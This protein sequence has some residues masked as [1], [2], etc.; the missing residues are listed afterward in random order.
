MAFTALVAGIPFRPK[1]I[2]K[3]KTKNSAQAINVNSPDKKLPKPCLLLPCHSLEDFPTYLTGE[4]AAQMLT[5][6]TVLWHPSVLLRSEGLP[7]WLPD[8][9]APPTIDGFR[10]LLPNF[11]TRQI[12]SYLKTAMEEDGAEFFKVPTDRN[13]ACQVLF[14]TLGI[15]DDPVPPDSTA[16]EFYALSYTYLQIELICRQLRYSDGVDQEQF[17]KHL[18]L[19]AKNAVPCEDTSG[20]FEHHLSICYDL[21]ADQRQRFYPTDPLL[22]DLTLTGP[23]TGKLLEDQLASWPPFT[24]QSTVRFLSKLKTERPLAFNKVKNR[25]QNKEIELISSGWVEIPN[26]FSNPETLHANLTSA[27]S[28]VKKEL[29]TSLTIFSQRTMGLENHYPTSLSI[30]NFQAALFQCFDGLHPADPGE[31][32]FRWESSDG[33][34]LLSVS[35]KSVDA[36]SPESFLRLGPTIGQILDEDHLAAIQ[37]T[38]WPNRVSPFYWDLANSLKRSSTLGKWCRLDEVAE[39]LHDPG[40]CQL[41][42]NQY[43]SNWMEKI[44]KSLFSGTFKDSTTNADRYFADLTKILQTKR[45]KVSEQILITLQFLSESQSKITKPVTRSEKPISDTQ[46]SELS[47]ELPENSLLW[48]I[49]Q[50]ST[51]QKKQSRDRKSFRDL[52]SG[53]SNRSDLEKSILQRISS[54]DLVDSNSSRK[55]GTFWAINPTFAAS[56]VGSPGNDLKRVKNIPAVGFASWPATSICQKPKKRGF[57]PGRSKNSNLYCEEDSVFRN[58]TFETAID[59]QTG[60][61]RTFKP[62]EARGNLLSWQLSFFDPELKKQINRLEK[63]LASNQSPNLFQATLSKGRPSKQEQLLACHRKGHSRMLK[64]EL[65]IIQN[66]PFS[67]IVQ[68][69]GSLA[70]LG[71]RVASYTLQYTV[72]RECPYIEIQGNIRFILQ[73]NQEW[74]GDQIA[75]YNPPAVTLSNGGFFCSRVASNLNRTFRNHCGFVKPT[76][77]DLFFSPEYFQLR[78]K[79]QR[80]TVANDRTF[81]HRSLNSGEI[82]SALCFSLPKDTPLS[83]QQRISIGNRNPES[84]VS[85]PGRPTVFW[86]PGNSEKHTQSGWLFCNSNEFVKIADW[87]NLFN[88]DNRWDGIQLVLTNQSGSQ[89]TTKLGFLKPIREFCGIGIDEQASTQLQLTDSGLDVFLMGYET[90]VLRLKF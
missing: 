7:T 17:E 20:Q 69:D 86:Q 85:N 33:S 11:S 84:V 5:A 49:N 70:I 62:S 29:D 47:T 55:D 79:D 73:N 28:W 23:T 13:L 15:Q 58:E 76:E 71:N 40:Y 24:L 52:S 88:D 38:H 50:L 35:K 68:V 27:Q 53:F 56:F 43:Y 89:Q 74:K 8:D 4:D 2:R 57:L 45:E 41:E 83:F 21:L 81:F 80:I 31:T 60:A 72:H 9:Q 26:T 34:I 30:L 51:I 1:Y 75:S 18:L 25:V 16:A 48:L 39:N 67:A 12:D 22:T 82:E 59:L 36:Y 78:S 87:D 90:I 63:K 42:S 77:R 3:S 6:W 32:S 10:F 54:T 65:R 64:R 66:D 46:T 44:G 61:L 14:K 37:V 19:A